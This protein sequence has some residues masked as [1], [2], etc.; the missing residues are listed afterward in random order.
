[1]DE[2]NPRLGKAI[3]EVVETQLRNNTPPETKE[4]YNRLIL[5]GYPDTEARRL[6]GLVV[7]TEIFDVL[8][9]KQE[10]NEKRFIAMLNKLP[11]MPWE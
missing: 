3:L 7:V 8:K 10:Y 2:I 4:T 9:R 6:I 11:A 1:M 5:S